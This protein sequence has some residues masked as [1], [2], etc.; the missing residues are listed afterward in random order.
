MNLTIEIEQETDG[1]WICE[2]PQTP[3]VMVYEPSREQALIRVKALVLRVLAD[4]VEHGARRPARISK[5]TGLK[6][7]NL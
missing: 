1:R 5:R 4:R 3:G 2:V 6:P 7:E